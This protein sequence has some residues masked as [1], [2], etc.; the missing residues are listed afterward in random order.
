MNNVSFN[1]RLIKAPS[2]V[3]Y[4]VIA[5]ELAHLIEANYTARCWST[6]RTQAPKAEK[7]KLWLSENGHLLE[8]EI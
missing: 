2:R 6:V 5:H 8:Q 7:A 3:V 1:W 4:Y